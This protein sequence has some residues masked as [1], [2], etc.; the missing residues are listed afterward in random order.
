M[1]VSRLAKATSPEFKV[2]DKRLL[3]LPQIQGDLSRVNVDPRRRAAR[4]PPEPRP[5]VAWIVH[6]C[7]DT[8]PPAG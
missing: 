2:M 6:S 1:P 4:W 8:S 3:A 5:P 7:G